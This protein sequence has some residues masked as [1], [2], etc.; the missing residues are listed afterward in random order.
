MRLLYGINKN[1]RSYFQENNI[2]VP[3]KYITINR[4]NTE[5]VQSKNI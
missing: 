2:R 4:D 3:T 1:G 5:R